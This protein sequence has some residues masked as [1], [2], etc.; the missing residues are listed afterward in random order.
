M[1]QEFNYNA[2]YTSNTTPARAAFENNFADLLLYKNNQ[3][4][5]GFYLNYE[6][7]IA[8]D[9]ANDN[10]VSSPSPS[11]S[12]TNKRQTE[13][14][15]D[16]EITA[17]AV[18]S[19]LDTSSMDTNNLIN[20]LL[21]TSTNLDSAVNAEYT[22]LFSTLNGGNDD[23]GTATSPLPS[24][25]I[26][27]G[28][29]IINAK[30]N[31][32]LPPPQP[33]QNQN[34]SLSQPSSPSMCG[35]KRKFQE[36]IGNNDNNSN[37]NNNNHYND[38][39]DAAVSGNFSK[40]KLRPNYKKTTIQS[41]VTMEQAVHHRRTDICT[42]AP[43]TEISQYFTDEF[44]PY[45][46]KFEENATAA[47]SSYNN[48]ANR[49]C[50]HMSETGY[51]MFVVKKSQYKPFEIV[52]AKYVTNVVYE[53]TNNYYM[54][55]NRAFVVTYDKVR[56]MISYNLVR[57]SGIEIPFSQ[58]MCSDQMA[59]ENRKQ[60]HFLDVHH[61]FKAALT[62]YFNLDLYYV[63]TTFVTK[64]QS[65]GESKSG[66]ILTKLYEMFRD[67]S[68]F[69]LPI[70]LSRKESELD[71]S[72][73]NRGGNSNFIIS[74]YVSQ[75]IKYSH[76]LHYPQH[77]PN[78]FVINNL[79]KI[80]NQKSTLTYKYSSVAN[81]LFNNYKYNDNVQC[82]NNGSNGAD[83]LKRVKKEDGSM[84]IVEQY[85]SQNA[86]ANNENGDN[87]IVLSFK[88]D[89]RLTVAKKDTHFYW[90]Y[91]ETKE[92]DVNQ[93]VHK[94]NKCT[95]HSFVI[96]KVNR[97]ESTTLHNYLLKLLALILQ[98]LVPLTNAQFFAE[99]KLNCKYK[100]LEFK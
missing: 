58:D 76:N 53:Y 93:I 18:C 61:N 20:C 27:T 47:S 87:F 98:N 96:G 86:A 59:A 82:C 24:S 43:I 44:T 51:Y 29:A 12:Q 8:V 73:V 70:M 63:Q 78:E 64:L 74:P 95:H 10:N 89:E 68:L 3:T 39:N 88:N 13:S 14:V 37:G 5:D 50:E 9:N 30:N 54:V 97:R 26:A 69:T 32:E 25:T 21:T 85:L 45:L 15:D 83:N 55:D 75:I 11:P 80:V 31:T 41:C 49:F 40:N 19:I 22:N 4:P 48:N 7:P 94:F 81:L 1:K 99:N 6:D 36:M 71:A 38:D 34:L 57:E 23:T 77:E 84:H 28:D 66:F 46:M 67:K 35:V 62:S 100:L 16:D 56:F 17:A 60:C 90:I 72:A 65:L 79:D 52:F 2:A 91:G 92:A 33:Q 42:V